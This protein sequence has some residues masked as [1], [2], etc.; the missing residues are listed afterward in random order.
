MIFVF[1]SFFHSLG[2]EQHKLNIE[3]I[4]IF[5]NNNEAELMENLSFDTLNELIF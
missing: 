5:V 3:L 4:V 1:L 2:M